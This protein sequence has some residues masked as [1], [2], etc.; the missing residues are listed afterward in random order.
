M[1]VEYRHFESDNN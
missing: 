1:R